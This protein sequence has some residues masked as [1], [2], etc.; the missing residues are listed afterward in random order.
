[1]LIKQVV[2]L[3][4]LALKAASNGV[5]AQIIVAAQDHL[6][7]IPL[8]IVGLT[9]VVLTEINRHAVARTNLHFTK[10][11]ARYRLLEKINVANGVAHFRGE[12][13]GP[14]GVPVEGV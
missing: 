3:D 14:I 7:G 1:M 6:V 8:E 9:T 2:Y 11:G 5:I 12:V 10:F 4:R 13:S